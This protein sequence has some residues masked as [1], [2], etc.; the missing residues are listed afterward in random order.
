MAD[1]FRKLEHL[2]P[3]RLT[4][5]D[6]AQ[7]GDELVRQ[8]SSGGRVEV[9]YAVS[10]EDGTNFKR[11][12]SDE[13]LSNLDAEGDPIDQVTLRI[14]AWGPADREIAKSAD[15][16]LRRFGSQFQVGSSDPW[17]G[18]SAVQE[19]KDRFAKHRPW[20]AWLLKRVAA[21]WGLAA[22]LPVFFVIIAANHERRLSPLLIVVVALSLLVLAVNAWIW[23]QYMKHRLLAD[24]VVLR[25]PRTRNW[26]WLKVLVGAV[27]L[28]A[29]VGT[30]IVL[31][32]R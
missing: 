1:A 20:Y 25:A 30:L 32:A 15:L 18:K 27:A 5:R 8:M 7:I 12:S 19:I 31:L 21:V 16:Q 29:D 3:L 9:E 23:R 4:I 2:P 28:I 26:M 24:T 10:F 6:L 14:T 17:W 22:P 11:D 13:F